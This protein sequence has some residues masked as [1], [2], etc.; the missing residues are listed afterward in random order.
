MRKLLHFSILFLYESFS[1]SFSSC[2]SKTFY[3]DVSLIT[4]HES[5]RNSLFF[6]QTKF[7]GSVN[8]QNPAKVVTCV[9]DFSNRCLC[10]FF[11]TI[12]IFP[13]LR[14][15]LWSFHTIYG[16]MR[17]NFEKSFKILALWGLKLTMLTLITSHKS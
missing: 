14:L 6:R 4:Q 3:L 13:S 9:P 11:N 16:M 15:S 8:S 2:S 17:L 5:N 12:S 10:L 7:L 1:L